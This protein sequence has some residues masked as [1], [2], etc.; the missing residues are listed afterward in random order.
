MPKAGKSWKL[1]RFI[2][3][4]MKQ[5]HGFRTVDKLQRK[6]D[7]GLN[8]P[9]KLDQQNR[10]LVKKNSRKYYPSVMGLL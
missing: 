5:G 9:T 2:K 10:H 3:C 8:L 6:Y 7:Q 1:G 4:K